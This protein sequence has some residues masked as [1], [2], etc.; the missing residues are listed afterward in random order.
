MQIQVNGESRDIATGATVRTLLEE[1]GLN[2]KTV[3]VQRNDDVVVRE[4]FGGTLLQDGDILEL[5]RFVGGG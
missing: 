4:E 3:V 5:V 1:L 2:D